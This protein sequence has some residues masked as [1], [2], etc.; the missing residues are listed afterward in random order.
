MS[1]K[2]TVKK[3]Q[4]HKGRGQTRIITKTVKN[5]SFFNFFEPPEVPENEDDIDED[6]EALLA[7]DFEIGHFF[8]ERLIPKGV[9]FFTGEAIEEDSDDEYEDDDEDEEGDDDDD[10]ENE[11]NDPDFVPPADGGK[12]QECKQQ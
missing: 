4:K 7:A 1:P 8:R 5:D 6:T 9:L 10:D 11:E 3:K 12:P 2:K